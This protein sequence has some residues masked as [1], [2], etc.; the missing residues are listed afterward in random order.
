MVDIKQITPDIFFRNY[1][2]P[3]H[4]LDELVFDSEYGPFDYLSF[5]REDLYAGDEA[6][7]II[8]AVGNAKRALHLQVET[9]CNGYGYKSKSKDFPPKLNFLRQIGVIAPKILEKMNKTRNR[10]E[11]AYYCPTFDEADDFIDIVELFLYATISFIAFYLSKSEFLLGDDS[12]LAKEGGW[13]STIDI[14]IEKDIGKLSLYDSP[15]Y[16]GQ[17]HVLILS[18]HVGQKE[19]FEWVTKLFAHVFSLPVF[20]ESQDLP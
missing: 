5:A 18:V 6:R 11:H 10:I 9:I 1:F 14:V 4:P 20:E 19:Y 16:V 12:D 2:M 7:N 15:M 13:P 17:D 3:D 8:N